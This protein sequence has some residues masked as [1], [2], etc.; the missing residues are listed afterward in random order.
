MFRQNQTREQKD[1]D[2][3]RRAKKKEERAAK[4][5]AQTDEDWICYLVNN[6]A[7]D[8]S[9]KSEKLKALRKRKK[10]NKKQSR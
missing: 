10:E 7:L 2:L 1:A 5:L 9:D 8:A 6:L 4:K 3:E